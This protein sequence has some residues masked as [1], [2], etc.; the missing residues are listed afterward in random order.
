MDAEAE[1][2]AM[3]EDGASEPATPA[4]SVDGLQVMDASYLTTDTANAERFARQHCGRVLFVPEWGW[5]HYDGRRW[6]RDVG[7]IKVMRLAWR[8]ARSIYLEAQQARDDKLAKALGSWADKSLSRPKLLAMVALA[9]SMEGI[10]AY[11]KDFDTDGWALN[12]ANGTLD[13]RTGELRPHDP[14]DRITKLAPVVYDPAAPCDLWAASVRKILAGDETLIAFFQRAVGY[15]LTGLTSEQCFF[16]P[17]GTGQNGKSKALG[18]IGDALGDYAVAADPGAFLAKRGDGANND[19]ARLVGARFVTA[20]E[21]GEGRR[22]NEPLVKQMTG[23][24]MMAA[25]FLHE[26]FFEFRPAFKLWLATNEKPDVRGT[27][28][29][30]WRRI[31]LIPFTVTIP[32]A[33]RDLQIEE[34]FRAELPGILAWAVEGCRLWQV[35]GLG[36]PAAVKQAT[37]DYRREMDLLA[38]FLAESCVEG[39]G[40]QVTVAALYAAYSA[41]CKQSNVKDVLSKRRL[42]TSLKQRGFI[43]DTNSGPR[44]WRRLKLRASEGATDAT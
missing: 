38:D 37:E 6:Q 33:E 27:D 44:A 1:I 42:G 10:T 24:D 30:I 5:L 2:A 39:D 18:A 43:N 36:V 29:A 16:I 4:A 28:L 21:S 17:Y 31:R 40:Y 26:E 13:L 23:G 19:I 11:V 14:G 22:L 9:A 41:W 15:S 25:R 7:E 34:K 3:L 35:Q 20:I 32:E 8:T 12:C